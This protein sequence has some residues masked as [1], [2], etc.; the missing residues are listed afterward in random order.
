MDTVDTHIVALLGD[1][2]GRLH[3]A[4]LSSATSLR[5]YSVIKVVDDADASS[6]ILPDMPLDVSKRHLYVLTQKKVY[7]VQVE[8]CDDATSCESC[9]ALGDPYCGWCS[10]ERKCSRA[11]ECQDA[12]FH[13]RW[14]PDAAE[15]GCIRIN[16]LTPSDSTARDKQ[17]GVR[18]NIH[19]LPQLQGENPGR[20]ICVF[21]EE[22]S[23]PETIGNA[24]GSDLSCL[25]PETTAVPQIPNDQDHLTV[26]LGIK[27][28]GTD[29]IFLQTNFS[30][31]DCAH[32]DK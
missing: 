8:Q 24:S 12:H 23:A 27:Y 6:A 3:K 28:S 29:V 21:G 19:S 14:L 7:R 17:I 30:F 31:Y 4:V 18:L 1:A 22:E 13:Q 15:W 26:T 10:L 2:Q 9:S 16:T 32:H 20:Y 5:E 25:T 11:S